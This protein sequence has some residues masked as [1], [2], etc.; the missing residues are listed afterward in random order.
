MTATQAPPALVLHLLERVIDS[1]DK[2]EI[3]LFLYAVRFGSRST[4]TI[5]IS[6]SMSRRRAAA[7]MEALATSGIVRTMAPYDPGWWFNPYSPWA[8]G[9]EALAHMYQTSRAEVVELVASRARPMGHLT[10][11]TGR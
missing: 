7:A 6:L 11:A 4:A 9:V 5:A 1:F 10:S 3:V 8:Q 2:L